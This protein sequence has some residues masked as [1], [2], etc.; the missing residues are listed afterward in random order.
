MSGDLTESIRKPFAVITG[1]DSSKDQPPSFDVAR[2]FYDER[3]RVAED[4]GTLRQLIAA[5]DWTNDLTPPQWA[6]WY[7]VALGYRPDLVLELGRGRGNSTALFCQAAASNGH[8]RIV[9]LCQ[10]GDWATQTEPRLRQIVDPRWFE[11]LDA[12]MTDILNAD[13]ADILGD[14]RRVLLL[15]DAHG[16][17]IAEVV[18]G[19]ILPRL[20]ERDHLVIMHDIT[21]NRYA[22]VSRSYDGPLWKGSEWQQRTGS[23]SARVNIGWMHA[24]QDQV[25]AIADFSAR[26]DLAIESADHEYTR[27]FAAHPERADD[28]RAALGEEF[29]ST[30]GQWA[31]LSLTGKTGPFEFPAVTGRRAFAHRRPVVLEIEGLPATIV[32]PA[33]PWSF[34]SSWQWRPGGPV[35]DEAV[36][37]LRVR[38]EVAG[39]SVGLGLLGPN[40]RDFTVRRAISPTRRSIDVDLPVADLAN[41]GTLVVTTWA[42]PISARVRIDEVA[43]VW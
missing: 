15:W 3:H 30:I 1:R 17:E 14:H 24:I 28:M 16:F 20:R 33:E 32:T 35:P 12:R 21:D 23:W 22:G 19:E 39:G 13:Y 31:Y 10:S 2:S 18:L 7:G 38:L 43:L 11:R 27:F 40:G 42:A 25:I 36:A 26:N 6:Q 5:V 41:P 29:F 34:A 37:S 8:G 4:L 9:S